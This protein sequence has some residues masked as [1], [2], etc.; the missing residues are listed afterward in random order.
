[1]ALGARALAKGLTVSSLRG[2]FSLGAPTERDGASTPVEA[3]GTGAARRG[4][5]G[6]GRAES[7]FAEAEAA[8]QHKKVQVAKP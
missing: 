3:A 4:G 2:Q 6:N 7:A 1:M 5:D 8:T